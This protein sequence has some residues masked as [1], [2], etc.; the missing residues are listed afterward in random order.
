M[1]G[2]AVK[3]LCKQCLQNYV[4][5]S[6]VYEQLPLQSRQ[7]ASAASCVNVYSCIKTKKQW[8][9]IRKEVSLYLSE[10]KINTAQIWKWKNTDEHSRKRG[11][12]APWEVRRWHLGSGLEG[13]YKGRWGREGASTPHPPRN[14]L[15]SLNA[16]INVPFLSAR[17]SF[18]HCL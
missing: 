2:H 9:T 7:R 17:F 14:Q 3:E 12:K 5:L 13:A 10:K 6:H 4:N 1:A 15:W 11:G 16:D 8:E 18:L